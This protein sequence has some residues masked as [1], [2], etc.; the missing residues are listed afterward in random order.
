MGR[1]FMY[2]GDMC[3]WGSMEYGC[4]AILM[5]TGVGLMAV[6][7]V[8]SF[9]CSILTCQKSKRNEGRWCWGPKVKT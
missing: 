6:H 3:E 8:L 2:S 7:T 5:D 1:G 9:V 4:D